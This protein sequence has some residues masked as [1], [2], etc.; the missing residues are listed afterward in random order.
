MLHAQPGEA[1]TPPGIFFTVIAVPGCTVV[2][3]YIETFSSA[4]MLAEREGGDEPSHNNG[5]APLGA[6]RFMPFA[7]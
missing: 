3:V 4:N 2:L 5:C 7:E 1:E 6:L